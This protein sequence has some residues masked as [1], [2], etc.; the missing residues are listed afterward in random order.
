LSGAVARPRQKQP[1]IPNDGDALQNAAIRRRLI[2]IR[3][4]S[5]IFSDGRYHA[6]QLYAN[7]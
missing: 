6:E 4:Y 2:R 1:R 3:L 5:C 7:F